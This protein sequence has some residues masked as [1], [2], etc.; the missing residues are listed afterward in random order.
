MGRIFDAVVQFFEQDEWHVT[1]GSVENSLETDYPGKHGHLSCIAF[2][3]EPQNQFVFYSIVPVVA[4]VELIDLV[5][6]FLH[7]V[8]YGLIIGNLEMDYSDG[9]IRFKTSVDVEDTE[10]TYELIRN[11]IHDNILQLEQYLPG[12]YGLIHGGL[13]I[14]AALTKVGR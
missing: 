12:I 4:P 13:D 8:N 3:A 1:P 10:L 7:R 11:T 9:E 14:E 2:A 5:G 6:T